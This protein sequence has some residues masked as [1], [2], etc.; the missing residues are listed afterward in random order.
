MI[1]VIDTNWLISFLI[2]RETS[3]LALLLQNPAITIISGK[4]QLQELLKNIYAEKFRK[5]FPLEPAL[6]FANYFTQ[7]ADFIELKSVVNIC[8]D[9]KDN[10]LL[11]LSKDSNAAFL[12]TGDN[13]L[14]I[15]RTFEQTIICTLTDFLQNHFS[16]LQE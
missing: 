12:I 4:E 2:K 10:Y 1:V 14:L 3:Q 13:D 16:K 15:L 5:Y 6:E 8:R 7:R 11:A 9:A